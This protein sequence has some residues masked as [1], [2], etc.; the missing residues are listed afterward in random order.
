MRRTARILGFGLLLLAGCATP[1][2]PPSVTDELRTALGAYEQ[3]DAGVTDDRLKALFARL[4]AEVATAV[5]VEMETPAAERPPRTAAREA[6]EAERRELQ[7]RYV[8]AQIARLGEE[9]GKAL[10]SMGE[11]IGKGIEEAG[12]RM[13]ESMQ[14]P[15]GTA[16]PAE[17]E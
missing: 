13:Q 14:P 3:G 2:A 1:A 5:A 17:P 8:K 11:Q 12:R 9:A 15:P 6:L 4:D 7:G 10:K 16:P